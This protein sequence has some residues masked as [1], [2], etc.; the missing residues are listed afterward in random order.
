M[1]AALP[2]LMTAQLVP[3]VRRSV[4]SV[5]ALSPDMNVAA[6]RGAVLLIV[7]SCVPR[8][9]PLRGACDNTEAS[10]RRASGLATEAVSSA[11]FVASTELCGCERRATDLRAAATEP[12]GFAR[13]EWNRRR[14]T[15]QLAR[16]DA[17]LLSHAPRKGLRRRTRGS[18][19]CPRKYIR[20]SNEEARERHVRQR[21]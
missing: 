10:N 12:S 2:P 13:R 7:D 16:S 1:T 11:K 14:R 5:M 20:T 21:E 18:I 19:P 3:P 15:Q 8:P 17:S 6:R 4:P 9:T